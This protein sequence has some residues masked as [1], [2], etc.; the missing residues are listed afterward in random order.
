MNNI[1]LKEINEQMTYRGVV[2][3]TYTI[4]YPQIIMDNYKAGII[5]FNN[6]Y[7]K[8]V[9]DYIRYIEEDLYKRAVE[10]YINSI[11]NGFPVRPYEAYMKT[12]I[13]YNECNMV[14]LYIDKYEYTGGAHGN[15]IRTSQTWLLN[16]GRIIGL[17]DLFDTNDYIIYIL[18]EINAQIAKQ[19]ETGENQ[20]FD[21]YC[22]LVLE[23]FNVENFY[24]TKDGI[25]IYFQQYEIAPYSSGIPVFIINRY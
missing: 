16:T 14:S 22:Q 11:E 6:F 21:N 4:I 18:R 2:V 1:V 7:K 19:I 15:T 17:N 12:N 25:A 20:Y 9:N 13:T 23:N 24:V 5:K 3:L 8:V 10:D